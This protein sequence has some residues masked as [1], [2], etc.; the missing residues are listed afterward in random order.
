MKT[1]YTLASA[2]LLGAC[3]TPTVVD[4]RKAGATV[5]GCDQI[6]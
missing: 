1:L 5:P 2:S 4:T 6:R 3:D